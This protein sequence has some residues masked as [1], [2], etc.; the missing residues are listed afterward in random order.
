[1]ST[2][3][4]NEN[5]VTL[6]YV[7]K[8]PETMQVRY[9]GK[10]VNSLIAR[11]GQ[12]IYDSKKSKNH[13]AYWIKK[14]IDSGKMPIIEQIDSCTW[15]DSVG[16]ETYYIQKYK[17][18]GCNLV[19]E[20]DGGE[21]TL[22]H[23]VSKETKEK[24][25][26]AARKN[27]PKVYQYNLDGKLVKEW[28]NASV[29]A[30]ILGFKNASGITR[31]LR[32]ERFKYKNYIWKTELVE[33]ANKDLLDNIEQRSKRNKEK[34]GGYGQSLLGKLISRESKLEKWYYLYSSPEKIEGNLL[35]IGTTLL[36]IGSFINEDMN[37]PDI[38]ITSSLSVHLKNGS[39]YYDKYFISNEAP[40]G[41]I[42][43]NKL[44]LINIYYNNK[45]FYGIEEASNFFNTSKA[46]IV[47]NL[48]GVTSTL[49]T[50][51]YGK[52]KLSWSLNKKF[53]RL[54]LKIYG[55]SADKLEE[56]AKK[57]LNIEVNSEIAKG[58]ESL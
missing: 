29:A 55:L 31:C 1:M 52:V 58:S 10:T 32:G 39:G 41:Y 11:L 16:M 8:D 54:Y 26:A 28:E 42:N 49:N 4:K 44:A 25:K 36:E 46:N 17:N 18:L 45:V 43:K 30:E 50:K 48:K 51:E 3:P 33:N 56:E 57:E 37:R 15:K 34:A 35:Y 21:G 5:S 9:V 19:N 12:H 27:T 23:K 6:I 7:L 38:D 47:N 24:H 13:R 53:C 2:T 20:T 14:I 22:G 40:E